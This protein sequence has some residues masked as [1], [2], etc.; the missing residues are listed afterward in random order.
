METHR[1][2]NLTDTSMLYHIKVLY[3]IVLL[4][5][6]I[7]MGE[8]WIYYSKLDFLQNQLNAIALS[9]NF[10]ISEETGPLNSSQMQTLRLF[11]LNEIFRS[12]VIRNKRNKQDKH[13]SSYKVS[14][15]SFYG[16]TPYT[17]C[18]LCTVHTQYAPMELGA[19]CEG[20]FD[21][22]T[23]CYLADQFRYHPNRKML[24]QV[25]E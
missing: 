10:L 17:I 1:R 7:L 5:L 18:S 4:L 24:C 6:T 13:S 19:F 22:Y 16:C 12:R 20:M 21:N 14:H 23:H 15:N 8:I 11:E 3:G 9:H 2:T 25:V